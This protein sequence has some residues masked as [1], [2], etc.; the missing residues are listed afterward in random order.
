MLTQN[1]GFPL[2]SMTVFHQINCTHQKS[3]NVKSLQG[4][5]KNTQF[6]LLPIK[7]ISKNIPFL[8]IKAEREKK[9]PELSVCDQ[10]VCWEAN[11]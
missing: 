6:N 5:D 3:Q 10:K 11:H 8:S 1:T 4:V 2:R 9:V 7:T